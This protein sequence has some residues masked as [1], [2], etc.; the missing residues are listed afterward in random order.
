MC[1]A[2]ASY[3]TRERGNRVPR[4]TL[5]TLF[6]PTMRAGDAS[7]SLSELI[8]KLRRKGVPIERDEASCIWLPR[9]RTAVDI[10]TF[11]EKPLAHIAHCNL[12]ILPGY[13]P[14]APAA[15]VDWVDEWRANLRMKVLD[16]I[17]VAIPR[18]SATH[19]WSLALD[20][21]RQALRIDPENESALVA[22][23]R[24][25]DQLARESRAAATG[26]A[27]GASAPI[28]PTRL[29]EVAALPPRSA[30]P[31]PTVGHDTTL[32]GRE[33]PM[34]H[35]RNTARRA[36][37][38]KVSGIFIS[39][40]TGI[41]K[42]RLTREI[43][44]WMS[45]SGAAICTVSC[46]RQDG[47]RPLSAFIQAVPRL[48]ALPGAAGCAPSTIACLA[49]ITKLS[50]EAPDMSLRDDSLQLSA[51]IRASI[52]DL[53]DAVTDEQPL[54]FVVEDV[55]W[56]DP[57]SWSMLRTIAGR[58]QRSILLICT[59]RV[60]WQ[61][62]I[63][64]V[65]EY[66]RLEELPPL[67]PQAA[68]AHLS[69]Y[70]AT[71]NRSV[72]E[73]Y[74]A[75]CVETSN[76]NPYFIEELVNYWISTGEQYSAPPSLVALAEARLA[77][78]R[79]DALR[80]IQAAAI[81]GKNSTVELL[82][83]VLEFPMHVLFS[84]IEELGDAGLL[85][86][87]GT[88]D[89]PVTA[90]V[91]CRHDLVIRAATRGLSTQGR[92]LLHHA[93]ARAIESGTA[94]SQSAELLWDCA[95]HWH[96]AGQAERSIH[97]AIACA[98][99]LHDMGLVHDA[100]KRCESALA[101]CPT[102]AM[103]TIV[104]R[105]MAQSQYAARDWRSFCKTV[106]DV[107]ALENSPNTTA[108]IHDDLELWEMAAQRNLHRDWKGA[109]EVALRCVRSLSADTEHR[110]K[111]S[112]AALKI[113]TNIGDIETMDVIYRDSAQ[114]SGATGIGIID[115]LTLSMIYHAIRGDSR[116]S[117]Q[118]AR[119]ILVIAARTLPQRHRLGVMMDCAGALRRG[120]VVGEAEAVYEALFETA[121][122]LQ[123]FDIAADACHRLIEVYCDSGD[124]QLANKWVARYRE[125][126]RPKAE[127]KVQRNLRL[128]IARVHLWQNEWDQAAS[129]ME[130][131]K[132]DLPWNDSVAMFRSGAL[133]MK[134]RL[135][136]GR[137]EPST[138]IAAWVAKLVPIS[139]RLRATGAQDYESYS[140]YLGYCYVGDTTGAATFLRTYVEQERRDNTP[141]AP[142]IAA[143]LGRLAATPG[144]PTATAGLPVCAVATDAMNT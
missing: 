54:L 139:A 115:R 7:H 17:I 35:L 87:T 121:V 123:C 50:S 125:L 118:A 10:E 97:A 112:I 101:M 5:E 59:S 114:L 55:H 84:S 105:S 44:A 58:A 12:D 127:L 102:D 45:D 103:R 73:Q 63:W 100:V 108:P 8:H 107:R 9:D 33:L 141:L 32:V 23:S 25:A 29:R 96:A 142:E 69:N 18:A 78:L 137:S 122:P 40:P 129:L 83:K 86:M 15:F 72:D 48:Q 111:A 30:R 41:G 28:T 6:W 75:W 53:V 110:V 124:I 21:V 128:A 52:I 38:G 131:R 2:L 57:V 37:Q 130:A 132:S 70:L 16:D 20:L 14:R 66:F 94:G 143:E 82:Q 80:V 22:G 92:S 113:A 13:S 81:L 71:L 61:H 109:L 24:A 135:D 120:G 47:H 85:T 79:P 49:R 126:R 67:D 88:T 1:F 99:H 98:R 89:N 106:A 77:C 74:T 140:L 39:G 136:I 46:D 34:L 27:N 93:A 64:G 144:M 119:E 65:P 138:A 51:A 90:P 91:L 133:A 68:R 26:F 56:I 11:S 117:V 76:G 95:D 4:R 31:V 60:G 36:M 19:D 134:I 3:L 43:A 104:L 62:A 116:V 42:S